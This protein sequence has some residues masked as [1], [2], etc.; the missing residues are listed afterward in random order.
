MFDCTGGRHTPAMPEAATLH[1]LNGTPAIEP[2]ALCRRYESLYTGAVNDVM[3]RRGLLRQ[4]LPHGILP[5]RESMT[6]A[7]FAFTVKGVQHTTTDGEMEQRAEMLEALVP[8]SVVVWDTTGDN[9]SAHW[10]EVMTKAAI[11]GGCRGAVIDGGV[12]DTGL[13]LAQ[14]FPV[15][16]RYRTSNGMLGRFR[17]VDYQR[18]VRIGNVDVRPGDLIFGDIDGVLVVPIEIATGVLLAAEEVR[19]EEQVYKRWIDEG[20]SAEEVIRRGGYF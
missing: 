13:V 10:G 6:V 15:F 11:R 7:G 20:M 8:L 1:P 9:E 14:A 18:P 19:V 3:R 5:L 16:C 2:E 4:T 17:M 12:R